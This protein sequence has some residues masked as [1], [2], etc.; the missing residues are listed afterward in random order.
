MIIDEL[1]IDSKQLQ[2]LANDL[3]TEAIGRSIYADQQRTDHRP[4][5]RRMSLFI[6]K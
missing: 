2:W 3:L 5:S 1:M 6:C 4:G